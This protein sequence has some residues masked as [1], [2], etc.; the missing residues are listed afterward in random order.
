MV[1][2]SMG[3]CWWTDKPYKYVTSIKVNLAFHSSRV[4]KSSTGMSGW[5]KACRVHLCRVAAN[6]VRSHTADDAL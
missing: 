6:T 1:T 4:G 3:D 5:V 2:N